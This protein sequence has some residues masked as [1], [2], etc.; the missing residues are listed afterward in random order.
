MALAMALPLT[1]A[2]A[3]AIAGVFLP[4]WLGLG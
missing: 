2:G 1:G 4:G 3:A